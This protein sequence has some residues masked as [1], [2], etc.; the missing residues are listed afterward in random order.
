[1]NLSLNDS[2]MLLRNS[3]IEFAKKELNDDICEDDEK[4][5]FPREKWNKCGRMDIFALQCPEE[6]GGA[7]EDLM[8]TLTALEALSYACRDSGLTHAI[9]TQFCCM[10]QF[11]LFGSEIQKKRYFPDLCRSGKI[12]AQAITEPD[13]GSDIL[14]MRTTATKDGDDYI[15]NGNKTFISNGPVADVVVVFALTDPNRRQFGGVSCFIVEAGTKG[16]SQGE[17][18]DKMGLRTMQ[19]GELFFDDCRVSKQAL[20]GGEGQGMLI[21]GEVIEW[22]RAFMGAAHLGTIRRLI[23]QCVTYG[24]KRKQFGQAIGKFQSVSH[25]VADMRVNLELGRLMN[26][27]A[28]WLKDQGKRATL[29]TSISKLFISESLKKACLDAVQIHG[30]Y[31][32]MKEYELERDLRDSIAATIYSGTSEMQRNIISSMTGL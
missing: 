12:A 25:K 5:I 27:K 3:I 15:L 6:Y 23:E 30:G 17:P 1:M 2:Q 14:S 20:L 32:F 29:E 19:N 21:F 11:S 26:Q 31:G 24:K 16:F 18:L 8:T 4:A 7:R 13:A 28:A 9:V 10:V 22:E